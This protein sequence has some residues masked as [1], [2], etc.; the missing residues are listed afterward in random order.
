M[1]GLGGIVNPAPPLVPPLNGALD[2]KL[3]ATESRP[4]R[5]GG[6]EKMDVVGER[7]NG[8]ILPDG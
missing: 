6:T 3:Y 5:D 2:A 8:S 4:D 7:G 1:G